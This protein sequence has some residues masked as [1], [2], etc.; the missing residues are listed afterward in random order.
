[1]PLVPASAISNCEAVRAMVSA[2]VELVADVAAMSSRAGA[3]TVFSPG[4]SIV[5][6]LPAVPFGLPS[7]CPLDPLSEEQLLRMTVAATSALTINIH[8]AI[9]GNPSFGSSEAPR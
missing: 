6:A 1:M 7:D 9:S 5:A 8:F 2:C 4:S 3:S